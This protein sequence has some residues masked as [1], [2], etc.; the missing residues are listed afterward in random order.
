LL[1]VVEQAGRGWCSSY[2]GHSL[3]LPWK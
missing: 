1:L 3:G 2:A